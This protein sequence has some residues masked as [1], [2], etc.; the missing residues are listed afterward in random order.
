MKT[1]PL[2][3]FHC[4]L[5]EHWFCEA[6]TV[7]VLVNPASALPFMEMRITTQ[8]RRALVVWGWVDFCISYPCHND[9][10]V[11]LST[12]IAIYNIKS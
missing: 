11:Q 7:L 9:D 10:E 3:A 6:N 2:L 1:L 4:H 5:V 12:T 8:S